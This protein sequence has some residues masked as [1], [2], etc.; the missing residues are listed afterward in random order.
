M[1]IRICSISKWY[2]STCIGDI[3]QF[4]FQLVDRPDWCNPEKDK[5]V[6]CD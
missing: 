2:G 1:L 4:C 6:G 5:V 3:D